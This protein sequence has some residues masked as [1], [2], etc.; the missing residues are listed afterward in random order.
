M[1]HKNG[2]LS[3]DCNENHSACNHCGTGDNGFDRCKLCN[4]FPSKDEHYIWCHNSSCALYKC[5]LKDYEW[6]S[7]N[8]RLSINN[9]EIN[10]I[11]ECCEDELRMMMPNKLRSLIIRKVCLV[12][13][14]K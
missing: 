6:R 12:Y 10:K 7:L 1:S 2:E 13:E 4:F 9:D 14:N 11:I 5:L 3:H 8:K